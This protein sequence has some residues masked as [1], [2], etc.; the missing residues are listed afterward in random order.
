MTSG[1][2]LFFPDY[3]FSTIK[4]ISLLKFTGLC[5]CIIITNN[6]ILEVVYQ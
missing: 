5:V 2:A 6:D 1:R 4:Y 3:Q